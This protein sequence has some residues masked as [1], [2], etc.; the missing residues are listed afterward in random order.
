MRTKAVLT[1]AISELS[2]VFQEPFQESKGLRILMYHSIGGD[3][4]EDRL[5]HFTVTQELF[6]SH[7]K[8]LSNQYSIGKVDIE[9]LSINKKKLDVAVTF[10]DGYLDNL[11]IAAP[12]LLEYNIPFTVF[13]TSNFIQTATHG[14]L[15]PAE[16]RELASLPGVKIGAHGVSH[17]PFTQCDANKLKHELS[18]GKKYL[19]DLLGHK[20]TSLA[21]PH[22]ATNKYVQDVVSETGYQVA[23]CSQFDINQAGSNP[24][25]LS[26]TTILGD[27]SERIFKQKISGAWDWYRFRNLRQWYENKKYQ[28]KQ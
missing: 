15:S 1:R 27:D 17:T 19:E 26:R 9:P 10:D 5:G 20:I 13:V 11:K 18:D 25:A 3:A 16:L 24:L 28:M 4:Y 22:G 14:F 21:Y 23:V 8:V 12:I 2:N 6:E 7:M